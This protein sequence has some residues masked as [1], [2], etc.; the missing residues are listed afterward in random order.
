M[1]LYLT[2]I[3]LCS[4]VIL[5]HGRAFFARAKIALVTMRTTTVKISASSDVILHRRPYLSKNE[6]YIKDG[7]L[8]LLIILYGKIRRITM[9]KTRANIADQN[10]KTV[11]KDASY[12]F[13]KLI[14]KAELATVL[15][16]K[17]KNK[18]CVWKIEHVTEK[19]QEYK[20]SAIWN[21]LN[22]S[23][24]FANKHPSHFM[25]LLHYH[26]GDCTKV[27]LRTP[28]P[29]TYG[30]HI[31]KVNAIQAEGICL[32]K[33]YSKMDVVLLNI[34]KELSLKQIYSLILQ[35]IH[36]L[37]LLH[38]NNY[39]HGDLHS[40]NIG[41]VKTAPKATKK[42]GSVAV[43]THGYDW[44]LIDFGFTLHKKNAITKEQQNNFTKEAD[45]L[46]E[47]ILDVFGTVIIGYHDDLTIQIVRNQMVKTEEYKII[48]NINSYGKTIQERLF[49]TL[50][51][52]KYFTFLKGSGKL[53]RNQKLPTEDLIFMAHYGV[54]SDATF[55]YLMGK[56]KE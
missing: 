28:P 12:V 23:L 47:M 20:K 9:V 2:E 50:Y 11:R 6:K 17:F 22:F 25:K 24:D 44:K 33:A 48:Q 55:T 52:D 30:K 29:M 41:A 5:H 31:K 4:D 40:G 18:P 26:F 49:M 36:A 46:T 39:I 10:N 32:H 16:G 13:G 37:R 43:P 54:E 1:S 7:L 42:L 53:I 34:F 14:Y 35:L 15:E 51:P 21:E 56:V 38:Q 3:Q 45:H 27:Q 8:C 19:D